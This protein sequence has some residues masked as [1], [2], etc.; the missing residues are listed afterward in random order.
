M[1]HLSCNRYEGLSH[2][3]LASAALT[4]AACYLLTRAFGLGGA[5]VSSVVA[6]VLMIPFV[7]SVSLRLTGDRREGMAGRL[8]DDLRGI[9]ERTSTFLRKG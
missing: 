4:L 3:Y 2:R 1:V 9:F 6:D 7:W 5:A 8:R